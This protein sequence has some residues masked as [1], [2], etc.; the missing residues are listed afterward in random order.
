MIQDFEI[1]CEIKDCEDISGGSAGVCMCM[2]LRIP[3]ENGDS[4][5]FSRPAVLSALLAPRIGCYNSKKR[6]FPSHQVLG[7]TPT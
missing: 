2:A 1:S 5:G 7:N 6:H 4:M 3:S